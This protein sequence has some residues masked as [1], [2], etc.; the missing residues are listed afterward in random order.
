MKVA[1]S[2]CGNGIEHKI[3]IPLKH[4]KRIRSLTQDDDA[5]DPNEKLW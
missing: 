5:V 3:K 2:C 1:R 4:L